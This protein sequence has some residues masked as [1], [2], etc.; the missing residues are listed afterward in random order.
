MLVKNN[1]NSYIDILT[2]QI[3]QNSIFLFNLIICLIYKNVK[4]T[5]LT[6]GKNC[7]A[8]SNC[9]EQ[10]NLNCLSNG[11]GYKQCL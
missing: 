2:C 5:Q 11:L 9:M 7:T 4:A 3:M 1:I 8:D 10:Y 6:Y